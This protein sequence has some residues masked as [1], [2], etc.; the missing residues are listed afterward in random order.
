MAL[1]LFFTIDYLGDDLSSR[2]NYPSLTL[3]RSPSRLWVSEQNKFCVLFW[4]SQFSELAFITSLKLYLHFIGLTY[5]ILKW[6]GT[7]FCR[8][9]IYKK[10]ND[11]SGVRKGQTPHVI[12][13]RT[14]SSFLR[15]Y[16]LSTFTHLQINFNKKTKAITKFPFSVFNLID[17][18]FEN[19]G[20]LLQ[21]T[22]CQKY[23]CWSKCGLTWNT[24][25]LHKE[26]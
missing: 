25:Q 19:T 1:L 9:W 2:P 24:T 8:L 16:F 14:Q 18:L 23:L 6:I 21:Q 4:F 10:V 11:L 26:S 7:F 15:I 13:G 17:C 5:S 3:P 22:V 20:S 12:C